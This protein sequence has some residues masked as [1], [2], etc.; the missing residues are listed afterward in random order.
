[1]EMKRDGQQVKYC[2][3]SF[4]EVQLRVNDHSSY[5]S[6]YKLDNM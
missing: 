2:I 3:C 4:D 5:V 6:K 1:M